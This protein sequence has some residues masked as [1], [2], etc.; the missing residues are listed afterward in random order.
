[1][2]EEFGRGIRDGRV[3]V[4]RSTMTLGRKERGVALGKPD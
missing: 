1:M 3:G 2:G 4:D